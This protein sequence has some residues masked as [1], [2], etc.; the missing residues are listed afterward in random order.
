M[1]FVR[2]IRQI[3]DEIIVVNVAAHDI[4]TLLSVDVI[5]AS[6]G[7]LATGIS[8]A[9]QYIR[10]SWK[11]AVPFVMRALMHRVPYVVQQDRI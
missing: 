5:R 4:N 10:P 3:P 9:F 7:L 8:E 1:F 11:E 2:K 6:N